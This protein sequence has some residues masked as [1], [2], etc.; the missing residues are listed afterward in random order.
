MVAEKKLQ[1]A[2]AYLSASLDRVLVKVT[3]ERMGFALIAIPLG[4][5]GEVVATSN[6]P[7]AKMEQIMRSMLEN[8][9]ADLSGP[10]N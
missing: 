7:R 4:R 6:L 5:S 2:S 1:E 3:G 8:S 9:E 10:V